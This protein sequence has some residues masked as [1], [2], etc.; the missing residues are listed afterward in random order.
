MPRPPIE[1][2]PIGMMR[3]PFT[4]RAGMPIQGGLTPA[5]E[6]V[7]EVDPQWA[8]GLQDIEGFSH[9]ILCPKPYRI[10]ASYHF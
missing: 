10:P 2:T 6:G 3:T 7:V 9:L 5:H 8:E 4:T 1:F